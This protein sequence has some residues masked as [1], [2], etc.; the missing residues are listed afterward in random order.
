MQPNPRLLHCRRILYQLS[1]KGSPRIM[2]WVAYPFS[3]GTCWPRK[4]TRVS[5]IAGKFFTSW[6]I[7]KAR[8]FLAQ[9]NKIC[10]CFYFYPSIC[11][12]EWGISW[13]HFVNVEFQAKFFTLLFHIHQQDFSSSLLSDIRV[14]SS[15]YVRLFI[16]LPTIL[17]PACDS[18]S[19]EFCMIHLHRS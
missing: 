8:D 9:E 4:Q 13:A 12:G 6:A 11:H 7:R 17:I 5:C 16:F 2:E 1:Q 19:L 18:S 10:H 14:V 15:A 3:K